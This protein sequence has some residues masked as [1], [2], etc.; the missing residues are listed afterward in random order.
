MKHIACVAAAVVYVC[1]LPAGHGE[2]ASVP[3]CQAVQAHEEDYFTDAEG[4]PTVYRP[5]AGIAFLDGC[6]WY[7]GGDVDRISAS[8]TLAATGSLSYEAANAHDFNAAT[9]WVEGKDDDGIGET[10]TYEFYFDDKSYTGTMGINRLLI[11]NGYKKTRELWIANNRVK[12]LKVYKD[13]EPYAI[14]DLLDVYELQTV[15]IAPI[16]FPARKRVTVTFEVLE[17]YRGS[18]YRDTAISLLMFEG[19]GVH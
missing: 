12:R 17:V 14:L 6:S 4:N 19:V 2:D 7:C 16:M 8:S 3:V 18:T 9:A 10:L 15:D 1:Q 5:D 13:G 11:A